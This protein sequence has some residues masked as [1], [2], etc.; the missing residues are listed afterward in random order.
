MARTPLAKFDVTWLVGDPDRLLAS[1]LFT[2]SARERAA[3]VQRWLRPQRKKGEV[4]Y[5]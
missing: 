2:V 1:L 4:T 5:V 3:L